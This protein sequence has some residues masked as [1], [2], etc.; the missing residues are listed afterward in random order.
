MSS[1][2]ISGEMI[3]ERAA[4]IVGVFVLASALGYL[5]TGWMAWLWL[6][7]FD[8]YSRI[9]RCDWSV[10][11]WVAMMIRERYFAPKMVDAAPKMFAARLGLAMAVAATLLHGIGWLVAAKVAMIFLLAAATLE[12]VLGFCLGCWLHGLLPKIK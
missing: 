11:R 10:F 3:D 4:R 1:C 2:P 6:L 9:F 7:G 8:F 12:S 5:L